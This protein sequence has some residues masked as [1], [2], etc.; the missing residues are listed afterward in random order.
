MTLFLLGLLPAMALATPV[1][2]TLSIEVAPKQVVNGT[3]EYTTQCKTCPYNLCPNVVVPWGGD[4]VTL[5]CWT[6]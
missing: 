2:D 1:M 6:K 3:V 5:S 4:N